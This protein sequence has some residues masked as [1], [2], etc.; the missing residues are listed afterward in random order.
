[1][2]G[3]FIG[4]DIFFV[5]SGYLIS[6]ILFESLSQGTFSFA[7]F[8]A[9]RIRRI[10]PAFLVV[11][12]ASYAFGWFA[13]LPDEY[14]QLGKH[15]AGG[16]GFISN[17]VLWNESGYFDNSADTKPL[18][19]LW[20]LGIEE[21]FYIVWPLSLWFAWKRKFHLLAVTLVMAAG[22]FYLNV[23]GVTQDLVATFY[24]PQTRYWELLSGSV[25]AWLTLH[26]KAASAHIA[27]TLDR[28][29]PAVSTRL[30]QAA[31]RPLANVV[32]VVGML[33]LAAGFWGLDRDFSFPGIWALVPVLGSVLVIAAGPDAWINRTVL[34]T[35]VAV[36]FG[37][38]SYPLY[39]WHWPLLSFARVVGSEVPNRAIR[40]AAVALAIVLAWLTYVLV[41][42]PVRFGSNGRRVVTALASLMVIVGLTGFVTYDRDGY[43]FRSSIAKFKN[44]RSDLALAPGADDA[45]VQYLKKTT[46]FPYC[47][48]S[49]AGVA[50]TVA[51]VGDSH[52]YAAFPGI[53]DY[54][55]SRKINTVLLANSSCP[56]L[57][58]VP[59]SGVHMSERL[60]CKTRIDE[61]LNAVLAHK[62]IKQ[63]VFVTRGPL[64]ITGTEPSSGQTDVLHGAAVRVDSFR[65]GSQRTIDALAR[66]GKQVFYVTENPELTLAPEACL[67][68]PFRLSVQDCRVDRNA[69]LTRQKDYLRIVSGLSNAVVV[70]TVQAFCP[71]DKC[72]VVDERGSFLYADDDHL[73]IAGSRFLVLHSLAKFL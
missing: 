9:R 1:M 57:L 65:L 12:I 36:W 30:Q 61:I 4:V 53:A 63:V 18:L 72:R 32:S 24:S 31:G 23:R 66:A 60:A 45:C 48:F 29:A 33:L 54:L 7:G 11:L 46:S 40:V 8:Y 21:Q 73:S 43:E 42:R 20:S 68:R 17:V 5:I 59:I 37:L 13:L 3:G 71:T 69:V 55:K 19:H 38:I 22:S 15:I 27:A 14:K 51:V 47:R 26:S 58:G 10:F 64:Y 16:A 39:L 35:R 41:E 34:S 70:N 25:L 28:L 2:K 52:A 62:D 6:T 56:P 44:R 50:Q 67:Q 49:D